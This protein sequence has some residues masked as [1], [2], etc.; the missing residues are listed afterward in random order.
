MNMKK[1]IVIM[2]YYIAFIIFIAS[3]TLVQSPCD[4]P[5]VGGHTGAPGEYGCNGC[6]SGIVNT[7]K[8]IIDFNID[9]TTYTPGQTYKVFVRIQ[10]P[11]FNKSGFS[12]LALKNTNN[13]TIG[14]F[15]LI[16]TQRTRIYSDGNRN[17]LSHTPC[18]ADS[19]DSNSWTFSWTAPNTYVDTITLY[20][21]ALVANHNHATSGDFSYTRKLVLPYQAVNTLS[22]NSKFKVGIFPNPMSDK[23]IVQP[24]E[25]NSTCDFH[26]ITLTGKLVM[27]K[28]N[29]SGGAIDVSHL[30]TGTYLIY[31]NSGNKSFSF[32]FIKQ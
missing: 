20:I 9:A 14:T 5:L 25:T 12:C 32:K 4:S 11:N 17:Y 29:F 19:L 31:V 8:A 15:N 27:K 21:G 13:T 22:E 1:L 7:G 6:H 3:S 2:Y 30:S 28:N 23:L 10:H 26:I 16:E 24:T 18:G